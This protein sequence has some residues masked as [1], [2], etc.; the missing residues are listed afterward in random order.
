LKMEKVAF[1]FPGQGS[2]YVG[3]G[4]D[5]YETYPEARFLFDEADGILGFSLSKLCFE[6]PKEELGDTIN[7]QPAILAMSVACFKVSGIRYKVQGKGRENL[8]PRTSNLEPA[9]VAGHSMG[10]YTALVAAGALDFA[11]GLKLARERGRV[12][13]EAGERNPGAM[14]AIIG[15]DA[16][17]LEGICQ[18]ARLQFPAS[19]VQLANYNSPGQIVISGHKEAL[20]RA[21]ELAR[22]RGAKRAI[23]LA[24]S[25]ASHS[26]LMQI[27]AESFASVVAQVDF[28]RPRIPVVANVTAAPI[29]TVA[30]IREEL[31]EQLTSTV[32]WVES[33]QYMI[34]QGVTTFV[35]VGPKNVLT[36]LIRRIDRSVQTVNVGDVTGME[37]LM[38]R[39]ERR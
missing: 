3:M 34:A 13:K 1:V 35:E 14:A 9:F 39:S 32:R 36:G 4:R 2:Q 29:T 26:P 21:L 19:S 23:P 31:V 24:V 30:A 8:E 27:A 38:K 28:H 22:E 37:A 20:G 18:E 17:T 25:I 6:G 16:G 33:V 5:V 12:M 11:A 10:E 7:T 15:L